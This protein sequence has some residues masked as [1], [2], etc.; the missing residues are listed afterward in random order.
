MVTIVAVLCAVCVEVKAVV[1]CCAWV[2]WL[3]CAVCVCVCVLCIKAEETVEHWAY[4]MTQQNQM[5]AVLQMRLSA[6]FAVQIDDACN[7]LCSSSWISQGVVQS[8]QSLHC[9][10][11]KVE[12]QVWLPLFPGVT[13]PPSPQPFIFLSLVRVVYNHSHVCAWKPI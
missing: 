1:E 5:T 6:W 2:T 8:L 12:H 13:C 11:T 9:T 7:Q 3:L 4:N 10:R